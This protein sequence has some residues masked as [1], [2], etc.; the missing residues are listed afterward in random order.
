[1]PEKPQL[2]VLF[3]RDE[4]SW[5]VFSRR[6]RE[7][8]GDILVVFSPGEGEAL[9]A[10]EEER[11]DFIELL[12]TQ[13]Q[14]I[15]LATKQRDLIAAARKRGIRVLDRT[16]F[17][18]ETLGNHPQAGEALRLYS[19]HV[20]RQQLRSRLQAM[21]LLSLPKIR[22]AVLI[23]LSSIL[24]LFVFFRLLPSATVTVEPRKDTVTYTANIFLVLSGATVDLPDQVRTMELKPL[25]IRARHEMTFDQ[26]S[27]QFIGKS[28]R[29]PMTVKN[30]AQEP[31]SLLKGTRVRNE[32]G[33]IFRLQEGIDVAPGEEVTV[34]TVADDLDVYGEIIGKRGNVP[35]GL[36]WRFPGLS[37]EEQRLVYAENRSA[38]TGGTTEYRTVLQES[39]LDVARKRLEQELLAA[40]Q[41]GVEEERLLLSSDID[42]RYSVLEY[43]EL[44]TKTFS[45]F[46]LPTQFIGQ[47][48][49]SVPIEGSIAY[50]VYAY[51]AQEILTQLTEELADHVG[52]GKR[53]LP[54]TV[55]ADRLIV[56]VI[57]YSD[58]LSWIKLT[59]DIS[60]T[61]E[62]VLDP[63]SPVGM[64]F[65]STVRSLIAGKSADEAEK[66]VKNLPEVDDVAV[67]VW[68][69]WS[70]IVPILP[71]NITI[72]LP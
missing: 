3:R 33:M 64:K 70:P 24:F 48:V 71:A 13:S 54:E 39:D 20:W 69:P 2:T 46:V 12:S 29:V 49:T 31:Y 10:K 56:H 58:D 19:P 14:R 27:K 32:A 72:E 42:R 34:P 62:Y 16:R 59:V 11:W 21:G 60:G 50:T 1:M 6:I 38:A 67:S 51:D 68:P 61:E 35:A 26:I 15:R 28:A 63:L 45:G 18:R 57:D 7:T 52:E 8:P 22:I 23:G 41:Q 55:T 40:A 43:E 36:K 47:A 37:P 4:E 5:N 44:T 9:S 66:I 30:D 65:G 53:L 17:L 25:T